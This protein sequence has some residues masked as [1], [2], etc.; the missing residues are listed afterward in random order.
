MPL[1]WKEINQQAT[2]EAFRTLKKL[3]Y[4]L[5][6]LDS[7][8]VFEAIESSNV[9]LMFQPLG[10]L[11]GAYIPAQEEGVPAGILINENLP[12]AKQRYSAAHEFCHFLR[13]DPPSV[14]TQEELFSISSYRKDDRE[15]IAE[16]FAASFLM[17]Y[18]I[19]KRMVKE[20]DVSPEN[21]EPRHV[22]NISLRL[23]SSYI[24]TA[25]HLLY[26]KIITSSQ[27]K[28]L[29]AIPPKKI[30]EQLGMEGLESSW[31][32][33]WVVNKSLGTNN[34]LKPKVGDTLK[35][36]FPEN[37]STGFIW[38]AEYDRTVALVQSGTPEEVYKRPVNLLETVFQMKTG[39]QIGSSGERS[40][41]FQ[42]QAIGD[43]KLDFLHRRPW[44]LTE[45]LEMVSFRIE[46][47]DKRHGVNVK[48]LIG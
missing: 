40:F 6:T 21:I 19:L 18:P 24:A 20:Q 31:N 2:I 26:N 36:Y 41:L 12:I 10:N 1:S 30:K 39:K 3:D 46:I 9:I 34:S 7:V 35:F 17:P 16:S 8:N 25:N 29:Q 13:Q 33:I 32:D 22:Y 37:P 27:H 11:A 48:M 4:D 15:R 45:L 44:A 23:G 38:E 14:D 47:Q 28:Q 5:T 42:V 43:V